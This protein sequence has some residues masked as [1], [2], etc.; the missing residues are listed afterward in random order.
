MKS[1]L[2]SMLSCLAT[3]QRQVLF[4]VGT[5]L[6]QLKT[7]FVQ[8]VIITYSKYNCDFIYQLS[9]Y[10]MITKNALMLLEIDLFN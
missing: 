4:N 9:I 3:L 2:G 5:R 7:K 8:Y 10:T 6:R 1:T